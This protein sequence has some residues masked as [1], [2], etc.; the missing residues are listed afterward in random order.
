MR[1][2]YTSG[3]R[4][5]GRPPTRIAPSTRAR[6]MTRTA[7]PG[8][9]PHRQS[10]AP[11]I[12]GTAPWVWS[13]GAGRTSLTLIKTRGR[14]SWECVMPTPWRPENGYR[15]LQCVQGLQGA[16]RAE[17]DKKSYSVYDGTTVSET[18][19]KNKQIKTFCQKFLR[20]QNLFGLNTAQL[21]VFSV[22]TAPIGGH[23]GPQTRKNRSV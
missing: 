22:R 8:Q 18:G 16:P 13:Q 14:P 15:S 19:T 7:G 10:G 12:S 1:Q 11:A 4:G 21:K 17:N 6:R 2:W 9:T 20:D 3:G 5:D 23:Q